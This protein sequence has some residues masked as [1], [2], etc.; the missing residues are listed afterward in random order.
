MLVPPEPLPEGLPP[1]PPL[2]PLPLVPP[3]VEV[4]PPVVWTEPRFVGPRALHPTGVEAAKRRPARVA[5]R[6][7]ILLKGRAWFR[8]QHLKGSTQV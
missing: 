4:T 5:V 6:S 2:P 8:N 7:R 1:L 3:E